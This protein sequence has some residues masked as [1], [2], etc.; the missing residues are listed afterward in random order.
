[1]Y[2]CVDCGRSCERPSKRVEKHG[3]DSPPY[4][5]FDCCPFCGGDVYITQL[6]KY[7]IFMETVRGK[8]SLFLSG[9]PYE[10]TFENNDVYHLGKQGDHIVGVEKKLENQLYTIEEVEY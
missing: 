6:K 9:V 7:A 2:K 1:M 8:G 3:L 5:E 10:V 4:E